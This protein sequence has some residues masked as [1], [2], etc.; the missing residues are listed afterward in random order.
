MLQR[1]TRI[2]YGRYPELRREQNRTEYVRRKR[3]E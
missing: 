3:K 1:E 2:N